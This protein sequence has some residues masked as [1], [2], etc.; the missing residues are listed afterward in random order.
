MN[1]QYRIADKENALLNGRK[2]TI[3]KAFRRE[4]S[5]TMPNHFV[6]RGHYD[7]AGYNAS[8]DKCIKAYLSAQD[9]E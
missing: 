5:P 7:A 2:V 6:M 4:P 3:F 8:D 1:E 9:E